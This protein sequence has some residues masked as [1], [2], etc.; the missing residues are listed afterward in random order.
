M[1]PTVEVVSI[2]VCVCAICVIQRMQRVGV[3]REEWPIGERLE[4]L[5]GYLGPLPRR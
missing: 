2:G 5:R 1:E 4:E 3:N